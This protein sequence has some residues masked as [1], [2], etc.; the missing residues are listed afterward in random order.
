MLN[1]A[2]LSA[3][4]SRGRDIVLVC[5][6]FVKATTIGIHTLAD[7]SVW[8][9]DRQQGSR[10]SDPK[11]M[12][13]TSTFF[14][15]LLLI[16]EPPCRVPQDIPSAFPTKNIPTKSESPKVEKPLSPSTG[17]TI[18]ETPNLPSSKDINVPTGAA[19]NPAAPPA[20]DPSHDAAHQPSPPYP[21]I[22][23]DASPIGP[24][25]FGL[26]MLGGSQLGERSSIPRPEK[27]PQPY[28]YV[29]ESLWDN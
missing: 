21:T 28:S 9:K 5:L 18:L 17:K 4:L 25:S 23:Q 27:Q 20:A 16:W 22:H 29:V 1:L 7:Y 14:C 8:L 11:G 15:Y 19:G 3:K 6:C 13:I 26:G 10:S 2:F 12:L 24:R